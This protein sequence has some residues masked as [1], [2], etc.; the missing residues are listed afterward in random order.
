MNKVSQTS[1]FSPLLRKIPTRKRR[2][3]RRTPLFEGDEALF[4]DILNQTRVY[5]EYGCGA[6]TIWVA[7][8]TGCA[9]RGVDTSRVWID[10]VAAACTDRADIDLHHSD[11][12]DLG[13]WG[14]PVSY[15]K[16]RDF[17]DYTDWL[18]RSGARPDTVLIDGRFRVCCFMTSVLNA[19]P[20]T[21]LIFDDYT[22]RPWYHIVE[23]ILPVARTCGRQALFQVPG[24]GAIDRA[25]ATDLVEKFRYVFD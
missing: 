3:T 21:R 20:G 17:P 7:R 12:G 15:S 8:N 9:I 22:N 10:T 5:G 16:A 23:D 4:I 24:P 19:D 13:D 18:W 25:R 11:L 2:D 1:V 14:R 6:S